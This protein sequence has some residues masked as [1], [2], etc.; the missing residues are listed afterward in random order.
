MIS[1]PDDIL[2]VKQEVEAEF[3]GTDPTWGRVETTVCTS[4]FPH[5]DDVTPFLYEDDLQAYFYSLAQYFICTPLAIDI[6]C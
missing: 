3:F 4:V 2:K 1:I 6:V 5:V